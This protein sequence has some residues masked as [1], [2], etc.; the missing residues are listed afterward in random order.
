MKIED[1]FAAHL[2]TFGS[3]SN[4]QR[5]LNFHAR[6]TPGNGKLM[7]VHEMADWLTKTMRAVFESALGQ[8]SSWLE[9]RWCYCS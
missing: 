2:K 4:H 6:Y 3:S 9:L 5:N 1:M 8:Q 7:G